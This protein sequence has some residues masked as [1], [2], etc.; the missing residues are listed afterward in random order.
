LIATCGTMNW[1]LISAAIVAGSAR[2]DCTWNRLRAQRC[3]RSAMMTFS[4]PCRTMSISRCSS[5]LIF[6]RSI[7]ACRSWRLT[8]RVPCGLDSCTAA[9]NC[10]CRVKKSGVFAR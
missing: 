3:K 1:F 4:L 5:A 10:A 8:A 7:S 6:S 2:P 9:S